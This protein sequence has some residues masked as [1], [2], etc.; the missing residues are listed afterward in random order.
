MENWMA[1]FDISILILSILATAGLARMAD[2]ARKV[3]G[4]ET[5]AVMVWM[6]AVETPTKNVSDYPFLRMPTLHVSFISPVEAFDLISLPALGTMIVPFW[7][8]ERDIHSPAES[9]MESCQPLIHR[10]LWN[11][12]SNT[13]LYVGGPNLAGWNGK[14]VDSAAEC[15]KACTYFAEEKC[16]ASRVDKCWKAEVYPI[17]WNNHYGRSPCDA[18]T[19]W[20]TS[21][22]YNHAMLDCPQ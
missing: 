10:I 20:A 16:K 14:Q 7:I 1:C 11:L 18:G 5:M 6:R 21:K 15:L 12:C 9:A 2:L 22:D 13:S 19:T 8:T 3:I 17:R 4:V